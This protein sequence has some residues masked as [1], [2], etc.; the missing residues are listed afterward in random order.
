M[1]ASRARCYMHEARRLQQVHSMPLASRDN[2]H[3]TGPQLAWVTWRGIADDSDLPGDDVDQLVPVGVQFP[4]VWRISG[5]IGDSHGKTFAARRRSSSMLYGC[6]R[7]IARNRY[8]E[9]SGIDFL[10]SLDSRSPG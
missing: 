5:H 1:L 7:Q 8:Q 10:D 9:P 3:V 2:A 4:I 6:H